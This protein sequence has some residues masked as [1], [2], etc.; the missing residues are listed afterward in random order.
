MPESNFSGI[1]HLKVTSTENYFQAFFSML[2]FTLVKN[3]GVETQMSNGT[4]FGNQ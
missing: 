1:L 4:Q 3:V 2:K